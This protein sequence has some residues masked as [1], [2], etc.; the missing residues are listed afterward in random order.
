MRIL[1][2]LLKCVFLSGIIVSCVEKADLDPRERLIYVDAILENSNVQ[3]IKL[4]YTSYVSESQYLPVEEADVKV[5]EYIDGG[6]TNCFIFE[7]KASG[8]WESVFRPIPRAKYKLTVNAPGFPVMTSETEYPDTL[9]FLDYKVANPEMLNST[10]QEP[11]MVSLEYKSDSCIVW[12]YY[13]DYIPSRNN[14]EISDS[15]A[16]GMVVDY[17]DEDDIYN[18]DSPLY[19]PESGLYINT[20]WSCLP[21]LWNYDKYKRYHGPGYYGLT[22]GIPFTAQYVGLGTRLYGF[23]HY[24]N[25]YI[26]VEGRKYKSSNP[27]FQHKRDKVL[28]PDSYI[29][30]QSVDKGYDRYL[31]ESYAFDLGLDRIQESDLSFLWDYKEVYSNIDNGL[32]IFGCTAKCKLYLKDCKGINEI[33]IWDRFDI[34]LPE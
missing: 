8:D 2:V 26:V 3:R 33:P 27:R 5:E 17:K 19:M 10:I 23:E 21:E 30:L 29:M 15:T 6:Q 13:A 34:V 1:G 12:V 4:K 28:H 20:E 25:D 7:R 9:R 18:Q 16:V 14:W 24:S 11:D 32:G 22:C 31:R